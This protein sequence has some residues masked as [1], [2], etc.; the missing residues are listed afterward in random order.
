MRQALLFMLLLCCGC[1]QV[2]MLPYLDQVMTLQDLGNDKKA[3][4]ELIAKIDAGYDRM[5]N[6]I[7]EGK[8]NR[9]RTEKEVLK[10]FGP[11]VVSEQESVEGKIYTQSVYRYAIQN[12]GRTRVHILYDKQGNLVKWEHVQ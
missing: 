9:Y 2:Q 6:M 3:Q 1:T 10:A 5:L 11:P 8:M 4:E 12:K 7:A